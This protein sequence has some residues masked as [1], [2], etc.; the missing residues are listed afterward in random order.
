MKQ[1]LFNLYEVLGLHNTSE[2][3]F[4]KGGG[5]R[6]Q[7]HVSV[8]CGILNSLQSSNGNNRSVMK[9]KEIE[10]KVNENY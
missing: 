7:S 1:I 9:L 4:T 5:F 6:V 3:R 8:G 10:Y 2:V